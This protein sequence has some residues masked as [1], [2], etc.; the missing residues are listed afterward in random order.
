MVKRKYDYPTDFITNKGVLKRNKL[1][2]IYKWRENINKKKLT[3]VLIENYNLKKTI[4]CYQDA[5][6]EW[7]LIAQK[8]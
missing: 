7:V 6:E 3:E 5:L 8:I 2:Q 1:K 4:K